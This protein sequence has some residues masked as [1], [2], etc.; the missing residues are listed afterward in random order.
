MHTY[1]IFSARYAPLCGGV[2]MYTQNLAHELAGQ[3]NKVH[4]ITCNLSDLEYHEKQDDNVEVWRVPAR[5][6]IDDRLPVDIQNEESKAIYKELEEIDFDR[7]VVNT[8]FYKHSL[9]GVQ[10]ASKMG[11]ECVV[12]EHGSAYLTLGNPVLDKAIQAYEHHVTNKLKKYPFKMAGVSTAC[13]EWAST[14]GIDDG[15]VIPNA[16]DADAFTK[17]MS[18][19]D[20]RSEFGIEEDE[21]LVC[22]VGRLVGEKG[23][24]KL[25]LAARLMPSTKFICAGEGPMAQTIQD[26][27]LRNFYLTG[28]LNRQDL[29]ALLN[30][31]DVF[32]MPTRSEGFSTALLEACCMGCIPVMPHVGGVDE[33]MGNPCKWGVIMDSDCAF[34]VTQNLYKAFTLSEGDM[35]RQMAEDVKSRC[36][37]KNSVKCLGKAF[38]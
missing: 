17:S 3:G 16:I 14:F 21:K 18:K 10:F 1:A 19:R 24:D 27:N 38:N 29:P 30:Q 2:E 6:Y 36:T 37:W 32:C 4:I 5:S 28:N 26:M 23:V 11:C 31:A 34:D 22:F 9:I 25:A 12:I 20:F 35:P 13:V 8:R 7:V 33:I 15:V